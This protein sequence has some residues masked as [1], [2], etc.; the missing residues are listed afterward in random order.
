MSDWKELGGCVTDDPF[1]KTWLTE[2]TPT[3]AGVLAAICK[4]CDVFVE[5]EAEV[6]EFR[7]NDVFQAGRWRPGPEADVSVV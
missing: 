3:V 1:D 6:D 5:C 4:R 2:P 7:S